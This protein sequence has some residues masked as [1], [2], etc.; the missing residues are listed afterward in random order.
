MIGIHIIITILNFIFVLPTF[1]KEVKNEPEH[2]TPLYILSFLIVIFPIFN[3]YVLIYFLKNNY[4]EFKEKLAKRKFKK[5]HPELISLNIL[6]D[7]RE[8][9]SDHLTKDI[10]TKS[11]KTIIEFVDMLHSLINILETNHQQA[12]FARILSLYELSFALIQSTL[13][14]SKLINDELTNELL[15]ISKESIEQAIVETQEII[16]KEIRVENESNEVI[17]NNLINGL[18]EDQAYHKKRIENSI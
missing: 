18:K 6:K 14:E 9:Y 8:I 13:K 11:R 12:E 1:L 2:V 3:L 16:E 17:R 10:D 15:L 7:I 4:P 5:K